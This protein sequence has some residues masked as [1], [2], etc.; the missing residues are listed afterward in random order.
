MEALH[1][2]TK[3]EDIKAMRERRGSENQDK[4]EDASSQ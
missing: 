4:Y 3:D 2:E 1:V